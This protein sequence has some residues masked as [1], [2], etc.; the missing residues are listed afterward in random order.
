[1]DAALADVV[2]D[3]R[4]VVVDET[5]VIADL[6]IG[7]ATVANVELPV[8]ERDMVERFD[9]LCERYRPRTVV[10]AG[11][12]LH[13]FDTIPRLAE[14]TLTGLLDTAE[15]VGADVVVTPGNH[16]TMLD[17]V[18]SGTT[19][20]EHRIGETLVC[21]GH[22]EPEGDATRYLIGHDHPAIR[23]EGQTHPCLLAG[24]GIYRNANLLVL[25]SFNGLV[26]G[27]TVNT[28]ST[29]DFLSPLIR[30]V[31]RLSPVVFDERSSEPLCFPPLGQLRTHL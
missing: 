24:D 2:V 10:V 11:D 6:H 7:K 5:L 16:D 13:S 31:D 29:S 9:A 23:I 25:P 20:P 12:V 27:V 1:M 30:N 3:D 4:A 26:T 22:V 19:T 14:E 17:A 18:W 28:L 15:A 8:G 21:H